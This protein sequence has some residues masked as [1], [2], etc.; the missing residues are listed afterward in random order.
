MSNPLYTYGYGRGRV[1]DLEALA[2]RGVLI[3]DTRLQ[4]RSRNPPWNRGP[5]TARLGDA[6]AWRPDL[7]NVHYRGDGPIVIQDLERG[8]AHLRADLE[9]R[10]VVLL[11]VC[12][13][14]GRCHRKVIAEAAAARWPRLRV[15]HLHPGLAELNRPAESAPAE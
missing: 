10:P 7:G 2:A 15:V 5:L 9:Q 12:A 4:P 14:V 6:Y 13:D 1:E 8:L 3:V 11:C